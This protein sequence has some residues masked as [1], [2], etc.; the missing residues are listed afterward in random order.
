MIFIFLFMIACGKERT[1]VEEK[2]PDGSAKKVCVYKGTESN[3]V[4]VR[5]ATYYQ[6]GK[7]QMEGSYK[8]GLR[9]G[10][11][12][13]WYENGNKW[14]EGYFRKGKSDGKRTTYYENG[15][16]RYEAYYED[17][18]RTGNWRFFDEQGN[19]VREVDYTK[20]NQ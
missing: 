12:T 19:L 16:V 4:L 13:F 15:K 18:R 10:K 17:D 2:Y 3:K 9:D 11:W 14:S 5:E 6:G 20:D 1:V 8:N 7:K